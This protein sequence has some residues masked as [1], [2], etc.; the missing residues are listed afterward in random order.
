MAAPGEE[1]NLC[2]TRQKCDCAPK[3][4]KELCGKYC[5]L[6]LGQFVVR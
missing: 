5:I 2:V 3:S 6:G 1:K 4:D